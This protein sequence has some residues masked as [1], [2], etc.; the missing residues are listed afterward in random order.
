MNIN[1]WITDT[2]KI[3]SVG[4]NFRA[5]RHQK[6][7]FHEEPPT[8]SLKSPESLTTSASIYVSPQMPEFFC[9]VEMAV[10]IG[11]D[12][13]HVAES[14]VRSIIAGYAI[15][16]DIT[17]STHFESGRFKMYD[18]TTPIGEL[19]QVSDPTNVQLEMWVNDRQIQL[20]NTSE[21]IF[22][23]HWLVAHISDI[24]TLRKG[25]IILTGT[26]ANPH[27]CKVGDRIEMRSPQLGSIRHVLHQGT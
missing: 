10:V 11:Q 12:A 24:M 8:L 18:Q 16:N 20:D 14:E 25:D 22:S 7:I 4:P 21:M 15:A 5:F 9:E 23:A 19:V 3:V 26:P 6:G 2:K 27:I 13:K 17:A 1:E